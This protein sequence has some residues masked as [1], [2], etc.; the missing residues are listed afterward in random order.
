MGLW[1]QEERE[2]LGFPTDHTF[3]ILCPEGKVFFPPNS[4]FQSRQADKFVQS[5]ENDQESIS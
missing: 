1:F 3:G 2:I 4:T 5:Y